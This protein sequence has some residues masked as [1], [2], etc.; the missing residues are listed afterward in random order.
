MR[1]V[2]ERNEIGACASYPWKVPPLHPCSV[3]MHS[4]WR[5]PASVCA[6]PASVQLQMI[7][8][9]PPRQFMQLP[10]DSH[11]RSTVVWTA[12]GH[13]GIEKLA[14]TQTPPSSSTVGQVQPQATLAGQAA[15]GSDPA[16][17]V[18]L[19]RLGPASLASLSV[20]VASAAAF[21]VPPRLLDVLQPMAARTSRHTG[22]SA[23]TMRRRMSCMP[24]RL[25][26]GGNPDVS[27]TNRCPRC[28][29]PCRTL[30]DGSALLGVPGLSPPAT[31]GPTSI[32]I[33]GDQEPTR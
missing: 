3:G 27:R 23:N 28:A 26:A 30:I 18:E 11:D 21:G 12:A 14:Q 22:T 7:P 5:P 25:R 4:Q 19:V 1:P 24:R 15:S 8:A 2:V 31:M 17:G 33:T 9:A 32:G 29:A 10:E 16:S 20:P 6:G 13:A